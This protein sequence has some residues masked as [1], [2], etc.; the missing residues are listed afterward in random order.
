MLSTANISINQFKNFSLRQHYKRQ[1]KEDIPEFWARVVE[2]QD[3]DDVAVRRQVGVS[4]SIYIYKGAV[5]M[6][7]FN[8]HSMCDGSLCGMVICVNFEMLRCVTHFVTVHQLTWKMKWRGLC[9]GESLQQFHQ[10]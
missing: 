9:K 8:C 3:D 6:I 4:P 5:S 10:T 2:M 1:V 7:F